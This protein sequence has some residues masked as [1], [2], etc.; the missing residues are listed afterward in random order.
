MSN[1]LHP[2]DNRNRNGLRLL[3]VHGLVILEAEQMPITF[4]PM[5][6][7][8]KPRPFNHPE[9]LFELKYDGFRALARIERGKKA[10]LISRNGHPFASF[11]DLA[12]S[13]AASL[14][15]DAAHKSITRRNCAIGSLASLTAVPAHFH[16]SEM[17]PPSVAAGLLRWPPPI[18]S[19]ISPSP[20][21]AFRLPRRSFMVVGE[22]TSGE[23]CSNERPKTQVGVWGVFVLGAN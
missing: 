8:R 15:A 20:I 11:S 1:Y 19:H 2:S 7:A 12:D 16:S 6:L 5:P 23:G 9:W 22:Q 21:G 17:C 18:P 4:Q 10:Q 13:I 3:F 14:P